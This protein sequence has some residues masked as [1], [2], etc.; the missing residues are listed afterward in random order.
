MRTSARSGSP[1]DGQPGQAPPVPHIWP[2]LITDTAALRVLD[3]DHAPE[4]CLGG[5]EVV[6][7]FGESPFEFLPFVLELGE[8]TVQFL[9]L[10]GEFNDSL[11]EFGRLYLVELP[12]E[13]A[14]GG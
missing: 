8:L 5:D 7:G 10:G 2:G 13:P 12:T 14:H 9:V 1:S 3:S 4:A 11:R 6:V